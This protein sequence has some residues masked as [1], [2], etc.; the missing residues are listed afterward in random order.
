MTGTVER[1]Y[2]SLSLENRELVQEMMLNLV[3]KQ[4]PTK[5]RSVGEKMDALK[6][7]RGCAKGL[8]S[9]DAV[10]YQRTLREDRALG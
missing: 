4:S 6:Q 7:F 2:D 9:E 1:L 3:V 5:A 8:W 10:E